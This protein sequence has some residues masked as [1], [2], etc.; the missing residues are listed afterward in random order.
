MSFFQLRILLTQ[1]YLNPKFSQLKNKGQGS[2]YMTRKRKTKIEDL[3][4]Q[5][6]EW[7][8]HKESNKNKREGNQKIFTTLKDSQEDSKSSPSLREPRKRDPDNTRSRHVVSLQPN[9]IVS[10]K[11]YPRNCIN[12]LALEW[13]D[14][15]NN[16]DIPTYNSFLPR[17]KAH[18]HLGILTQEATGE[19]L[20]QDVQ[21]CGRF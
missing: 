11:C 17:M 18:I 14:L 5:P 6:R 15:E 20:P 1:C 13:G 8:N 3:T 7:R 12:I 16:H 9:L 10:R 2:N 21:P 19:N 4:T